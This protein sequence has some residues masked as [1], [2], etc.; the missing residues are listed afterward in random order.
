MGDDVKNAKKSSRNEELKEC[1]RDK[2]TEAKPQKKQLEVLN[3]KR[4]AF[5]WFLK[6]KLA[7]KQPTKEIWEAVEPIAA[8][9]ERVIYKKCLGTGG[10]Y[11][12]D[13]RS[14]VKGFS[15]MEISERR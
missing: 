15:I 7:G 14:R 12:E 3:E 10:N 6:E 1:P 11:E 13:A 9:I 5:R 8:E 2:K 4:Q